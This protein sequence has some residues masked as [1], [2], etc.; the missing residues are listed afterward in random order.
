W[1]F[2]SLVHSS[3]ALSALRR[4]GLRTASTTAKPCQGD[5]L[6]F[7]LITGSI[8]TDQ[9]GTVVLATLFNG[10]LVWGCDRLVSRAKVIENQVMAI[11]IILIS[12]DSLEESVGA[13]TAR[14][15]LFGTIPTTIPPTTPTIDLPVIHDDTQLTP[16]VLP[17][18]PTIPHV[19]PTIQY[20]SLFIDTDL[21]D[22][23]TPDSPQLQDP[24]DVLILSEQPIPIG[25]PYR[26]QPDGVLKMLTA[27]KSVG[28]LPTHRLES[29]YPSDSS[30]SD[31]SSRHSSLSYAISETFCDSS[32]GTS[33]RPSR[34][35][36]RSSSVPVSSLMCGALSP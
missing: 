10:S 14:V 15:I 16:I 11:S 29:R 35:R 33:K 34:K 2:N 17:T 18:I 13:S 24:P 26:T 23:D 6:E 31:S 5:S 19:A 21:S 20:T 30:S 1:V 32:T 22:S 7:Y 25:R 27:G 3:H 36:C 28:S 4:S 9:Q 8:H 12:S